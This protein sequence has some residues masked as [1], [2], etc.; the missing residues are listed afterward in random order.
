MDWVIGFAGSLFIAGAAFWKHS[1]SLSGMIAAVIV[2]TLLYEFGSLAWF[3]TLIAFFV[4]STL[5]SKWKHSKKASFE[6]G[7]EKT[8]RRDAGQVFANGGVAVVLSLAN[9]WW[10]NPLWWPAFVG[11]MA[12]VNGDTWAT[13]IGSLSKEQPR[14]VLSGKKVPRGTSGG[15]SGLGLSASLA[16]GLFIGFI[17]GLLSAVQPGQM[18]TQIPLGAVHTFI[19]LLWIGSAA[20]TFGSLVD[21]YLGARWQVMYRCQICNK[22]VERNIHCGKK[23]LRIQ[24]FRWMNNDFVNL[25]SSIAGGILAV[26]LAFVMG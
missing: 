17:G 11:V 10:P 18:G 2:G 5:L 7:Y 19:D 23:T 15:V 16:G 22:I 6:E 12:T 25:L 8:G 3:G 20:G 24:G 1:L 4:S 13:E 21:S 14:S 9:T 26:L